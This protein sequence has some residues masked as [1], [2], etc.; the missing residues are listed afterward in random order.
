[1]RDPGLTLPL[2]YVR[3]LVQQ[4]RRG[5]VDVGRWLAQLG[6]DEA[7]LGDPSLTISYPE[8]ERIALTAQRV[9]NEPAL[10]LLVGERLLASSH[11]I[12]GYAAMNSGTT[13]QA[14]DLVERFARLRLSLL[15]ITCE[16]RRGEARVRFRATSPL[17][18]LERP[19]LDAVLLS[20][21]KVLDAIAAGVCDVTAVAFPFAAPDYAGLARELFGCEVRYG[22][23]WAGL[24]L[25][26]DRLDVPLALADP[27]A[28]IEATRICQRELDKFTAGES[29]AARVQRLLL[30]TQHG[31]PSL[32]VT[33]RI[34]HL[35]PRTLHRRLLDEGTS[36]RALLEEVRHALAVEHLKSGNLGIEQIAYALGYSELANFRRAFKCWEGVAPSEYRARHAAAQ[37]RRNPRVPHQR[38]RSRAR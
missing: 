30:E 8:F 4:V 23:R 2:L 13:R 32:A 6:L 20:I 17:G 14:I 7:R 33:A 26:A 9:T 34:F 12:V 18:D 5:G 28:F 38:H 10:G 31:F 24:V 25:P 1:M 3:H 36:F 11:G 15:S 19:L 27:D 16:V 21:K 35:A 22:E 29:L 37:R